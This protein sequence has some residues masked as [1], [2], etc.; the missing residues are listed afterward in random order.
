MK[1]GVGSRREIENEEGMCCCLFTPLSPLPILVQH[2]YM[3]H[4]PL[5]MYPPFCLPPL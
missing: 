5:P 4:L 2:V 1:F 3:I